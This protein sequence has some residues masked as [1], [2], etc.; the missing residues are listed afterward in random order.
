[1][2]DNDSLVVPFFKN[3]AQHDE[4]ASK[5]A[6][7][8]I[9]HDTEMVEVRIAGERNFSPVFPAHAMWRRIDGEEVTYAQRW[10]KQYERFKENTTQIADGTPLS[11]LPFLTEAK[12]K[13]LQALKVYTAEALASL[14]GKNLAALGANGR[15]MKNQA[16]AFL[17]SAQGTSHATALA[18]E[19]EDLKAQVALLQST[20][21]AAD[22]PIVEDDD[23]KAALK[24]QY[25]ELVGS[26]PRGNPSIA[27][28]QKMVDEAQAAQ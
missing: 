18:A 26:Y 3:V 6:G 19:I 17:L 13:E 23:G 4:H 2:Q 21:K 28:L 25:K 10:P 5:K 7:R 14:D 16:E 22:E 8:P 11:E 1:M 24:E 27:T 9:Y 12:R 15:T 20:A